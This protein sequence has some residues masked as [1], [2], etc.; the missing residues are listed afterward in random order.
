MRCM[1]DMADLATVSLV[2]KA[3]SDESGG[4]IFFSVLDLP[5]N[6]EVERGGL[7]LVLSKAADG[8]LEGCGGLGYITRVGLARSAYLRLLTNTSA[9][10]GW[11]QQPTMLCF[12][13]EHAVQ[14]L[15]R[16][17]GHVWKLASSR[18]Q[19]GAMWVSD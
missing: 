15:S 6:R 18:V 13:K 11:Q 10:I 19:V 5:Y 7:G 1:V 8:R 4:L 12:A 9:M 2:W 14:G 16:A 3:G 17:W